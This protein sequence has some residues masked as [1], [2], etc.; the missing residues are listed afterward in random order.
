M[1]TDDLLNYC[2]R[3][4]NSVTFRYSSDFLRANK[5]VTLRNS[6][7]C[8]A[9]QLF[10][11]GVH[12]S[13]TSICISPSAR[14]LQNMETLPWQGTVHISCEHQ[15]KILNVQ[16][17]KDVVEGNAN[18]NLMPL[19]KQVSAAPS[20]CIPADTD[21]PSLQT[22]QVNFS[23]TKIGDMSETYIDLSNVST[24]TLRWTISVFAP[25]YV[26]GAD[27]S[28]DVF[29]ATYKVFAFSEKFGHLDGKH[30]IQ[31]CVQFMPR[32]KGTFS[33]FWE[34]QSRGSTSNSSIEE[35][36]KPKEQDARKRNEASLFTLEN[37]EETQKFSPCDIGHVQMLKVQLKNRSSAPQ[38]VE[39]IT[40]Q[41]PFVVKH[42]SFTLKPKSFIRFPIEFRPSQHGGFDGLVIF[43]ANIG[44]TVS[45][46]VHGICKKM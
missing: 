41:L 17:R 32:S 22:T 38:T 34:V 24:E 21:N 25:P 23:P 29:R 30:T 9:S 26:K 7:T 5:L 15:Y 31:I 20:I 16:I 39:V 4:C 45:C 19:F 6:G 37:E 11:P 3:S 18:K 14:V 27:N 46:K 1:K 44:S 33:Q 10:D 12:R 35:E 42:S 2:Q 40:P 13:T 43:K 36:K 28:K 8:I